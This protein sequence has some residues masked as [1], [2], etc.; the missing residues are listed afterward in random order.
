MLNK[1]KEI[2]IKKGLTQKQVADAVGIETSA[3]QRY[4]RDST[5]PSVTT[6]CKIAK[7]IG[8]TVEEIW[9]EDGQENKN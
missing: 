7:V 9:G 8:V 2:R 5:L 6:A 1:L 4:E 3:Y